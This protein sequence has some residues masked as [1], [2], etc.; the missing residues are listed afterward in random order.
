MIEQFTT[1]IKNDYHR[2]DLSRDRDESG[3]TRADI[4]LNLNRSH[5][6]SHRFLLPNRSAVFEDI[7]SKHDHI[8]QI[9][10]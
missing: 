8:L 1:D 9:D 7:K 10:H 4:S 3:L 2:E 5:V 6:D